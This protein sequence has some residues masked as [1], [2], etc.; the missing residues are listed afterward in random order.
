M[1][2]YEERYVNHRDWILDHL[3]LLQLDPKELEIVLLID[4]MNEHRMT[5]SVPDLAA[6]SSLSQEEIDQA[7]SLLCA[8]GYLSILAAKDSIQWSLTG[9]FEADTSSKTMIMDQNL[10]DIFE[11]EFKRTLSPNEMQKISDWNRTTDKKLIIYALRE[12]SAYQ[13]LSFAYIDRILKEWKQ[14]GLTSAAI[15][16]E[17]SRS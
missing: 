5:I 12:A 6:K 10:I 4:F 13:S 14:K 9:L 3:E 17:L 2:W 7:V 8:K 16:S 1:K 11:K 15:E